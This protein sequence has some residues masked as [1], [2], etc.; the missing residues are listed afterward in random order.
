MMYNPLLDKWEKLH[1][2]APTSHGGWRAN[3]Q[4]F[5]SFTTPVQADTFRLRMPPRTCSCKT[6]G[7]RLKKPQTWQIEPFLY[8]WRQIIW[9]EN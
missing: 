9:N 5:A 2:T 7:E 8:F 1:I 3:L 4:V 6:L